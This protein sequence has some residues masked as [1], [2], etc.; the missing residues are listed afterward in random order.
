[1]GWPDGVAKSES[2]IPEYVSVNI[3][4]KVSIHGVQTEVYRTF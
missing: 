1:M 4:W 3:Y 2:I